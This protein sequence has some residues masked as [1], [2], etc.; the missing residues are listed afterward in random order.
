MWEVLRNLRINE[1]VDSMSSAVATAKTLERRERARTSSIQVA[2]QTLATK[3]RVG[4][5]T[6]E[7]LIRG[8]VKRIDAEIKS[9]LDALLIRE[10]EAEIARLTH[11]LEVARQSGAHPVSQHVGAIEAHLLAARSLLSGTENHITF[12]GE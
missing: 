5:G 10:L 6:L 4:V 3:L 11:D 7:N 9:R 8:R 1:R 12:G 2:R